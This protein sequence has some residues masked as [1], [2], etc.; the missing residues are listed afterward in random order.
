M[1]KVNQ[2]KTIC[3]IDLRRKD[4]VGSN[5]KRGEGEVFKVYFLYII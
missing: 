4:R 1:K 2:S 3:D 5:L